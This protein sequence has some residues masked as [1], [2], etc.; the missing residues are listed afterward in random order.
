MNND[1]VVIE[2]RRHQMNDKLKVVKEII[3]SNRPI[4]NSEANESLSLLTIKCRKITKLQK[5]MLI[6]TARYNIVPKFRPVIYFK[7]EKR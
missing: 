2:G 6:N 4:I 1:E 3:V 7:I 5:E